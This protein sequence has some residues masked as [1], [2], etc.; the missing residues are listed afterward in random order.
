MVKKIFLILLFLIFSLNFIW[1]QITDETGEQ[2]EAAIYFKKGLELANKGQYDQAIIELQ[3]ALELNINDAQAKSVLGTIYA[4][5]NMDTEAIKT[6]KEAL[7]LNP[8]LAIAHYT[9]GMI[10]EKKS[11]FKEAINEWTQFM[12]LTSNEDLRKLAQKHLE[13]LKEVQGENK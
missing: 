10:Y 7:K 3:K 11:L 1:A 5:K 4:Y 2:G 8:K 9:L 12:E 13:R 6:L